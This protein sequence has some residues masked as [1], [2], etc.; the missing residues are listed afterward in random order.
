M[1]DEMKLVQSEDGAFSAYDD[2]YDIVI[3]CESKEEQEKAIEY[4]KSTSWIPVSERLPEIKMDYEECYLVTDGRFCWM[5]YY[6]SEKKWIFADCTNCKNKID[7]TDV[8]AWMPLPNP[9]KEDDV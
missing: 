6:I 9:M 3:H 5:A 8:I 7:W 1:S 2:T 4:L